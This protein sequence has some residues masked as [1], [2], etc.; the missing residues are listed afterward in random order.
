MVRR[1]FLSFIVALLTAIGL[2]LPISLLTSSSGSGSADP[3]RIL[4]YQAQYR[5]DRDGKLHAVET[6]TT[7]FP[8]GRHG[9]FRYWD[10]ADS[11]DPHVRYVPKDIRVSLDGHSEPFTLLWE[12]GKRFRVAKI[13][14]A[15]RYVDS[16]THE[17]VISYTIDGVLEPA[18]SRPGDGEATASWGNR[19]KSRFRWRVVADG[20]S[21]PIAQSRVTVAL[22]APVTSVACAT[23]SNAPCEAHRDGDDSVVVTTG[24]LGSNNGV[25]LL[26]DLD[27]APPKRST[28]PWS[29]RLDP[30]LGRSLPLVIVILLVS[31]VTLAL[32]AL[33][34][35]RSREEIPLLP[36]MF[37]PPADP[38]R[39][40][41][42]SPVQ[43]Y[44]V[45]HESVPTKAL[46]AT[47][48]FLAEQKLVRLVREDSGD[49]T[50]VSEADAQT[51]AQADPVCQAA[52]QALG[53]TDTGRT[54][55]A[56]GTVSAGEEL[57][58]AQ[59]AV[60]TAVKI[61]GVQSGAIQRSA[62]ESL[63]RGLVFVAFALAALML[64][65]RWY[66][67][68]LVTLPIAA[69]AIGGAGLYVSGVGTRRTLLGRD[70]W[71]RA[72]GFER[73]LSTTSNKERLDFSAR[74]DLYTSYIP[75]AVAFGAAAA[76]A[77]KYRMAMGTEPPT[78]SWIVTPHGTPVPAMLLSGPGGIGSFESSLSSSISAYTASQA[79]SSSSGGGFS[80]GGFSGGGGGGGGGGSW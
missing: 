44:Y 39:R 22:P 32:G 38:H 61:W 1:V 7:E 43:A 66:P 25:A 60:D 35:W 40:G 74:K 71:S 47:L 52:G 21:M 76:W 48:L 13:G 6:L 15:D 36:V 19:D 49:F 54:F 67:F 65:F 64:I 46:T 70:I 24:N 28:V 8:L 57:Q 11:S 17:Y 78:P 75:Y 51:W 12:R 16:G 33:W 9:I 55:K 41:F 69:F 30:V 18:N 80:G 59:S 31:L 27:L 14:S 3:V 73:L 72:G 58:S 79:A 4:D 5:V 63:G 62:F 68:S 29:I 45:A 23:S 2:C 20:W 77:N 53:I 42:L 34:T 37:E 50:V 56:D 10:V 26:A